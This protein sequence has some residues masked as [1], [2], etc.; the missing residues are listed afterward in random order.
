MTTVLNDVILPES[1]LLAGVRGRNS[2]MNQ[3]ATNQAGFMQTNIVWQS[4]LRR[5]EVGVAPMLPEDWAELQGLHEVTEGGAY[6]FLML[7]PKDRVAS[8]TEGKLRGYTTVDLGTAGVGYGL[9]SYRLWKRYTSVGSS[10]TKDRRISRPKSTITVYRG[11]SPVT[12]GVAAGNIAINYDTGTI[13][14]VADESQAMS[15]ISVGATTV[16]NFASGT[17][18][19][20]SHDIG[21]RIYLTDVAGTAASTL[22]GTSHA[23]TAKGATSLTISTVTTGLTATGGNAHKYPQ[24]DEAL[25]WAGTFYVPVQFETDDLEWDLVRAGPADTR[26]IGTSATLVEVRE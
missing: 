20:A 6:G 10:R 13:T 4:T 24:A 25:T 16:L 19:V 26:L 17:G 1:I 8:S 2:R 22:N 12:V 5:Y 23:I 9:P 15:S 14:F 7:D 18:V 11:G 21:D 3:R